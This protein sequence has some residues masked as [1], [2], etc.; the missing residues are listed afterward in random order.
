MTNY[1]RE[2]I[3]ETY[4]VEPGRIESLGGGFYGRAFRIKLDI[5]PFAVVAKLYLY[6]GFAHK[7]A[8]QLQQLAEYATLK[9]PEV[10]KVGLA[11]EKHR[12]YDYVLMESLP[13]ENLGCMDALTM[14]DSRRQSIR[15]QVVDNLIAY[16]NVSNPEGFG[17]LAGGSLFPT[18]QEYYYPIACNVVQKSHCLHENGQITKEILSIVERAIAQFDDIFDVPVEKSSLIHG[19]YNTWNILLDGDTCS[20]IDP[21]HCC[22]A[23]SEFDLYQLDNANGQQLGLLELYRQKKGLSSNFERK[24]RFYELFTELNH[25]YDAHV[26]VYQDLITAQGKR[27]DEILRSI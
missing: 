16:H 7:E 11:K 27:L 8:H 12:G 23:D 5:P 17:P 13:G 19:D 14:P 26:D 3:R 22:W 2:I 1:I 9:M 24:K 15:R 25:Y 18:W 20:V 21:F 10:Y 6:P 4:A